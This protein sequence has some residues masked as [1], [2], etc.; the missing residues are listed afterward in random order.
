MPAAE[1]APQRL[2]IV[3]FA[4]AFD[5]VH[6]ALTIAAAAL[7]VNTP[8]TLFF[9]MGAV[10]ALL[11]PGTASGGWRDLHHTEDGMAPTD[12]DARLIARKLAGFEE[13]LSSCVALGATVMVCEMGL[14]AMALEDAV[15]R[16]DVPVIPGGLVTFLAGASRDGALLFV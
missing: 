13:M 12:A 7:A 10:R 2:S 9:T 16:D 4:G 14:R 8:T 5:R 1:S 11:P 6:Y 3:L 15:L